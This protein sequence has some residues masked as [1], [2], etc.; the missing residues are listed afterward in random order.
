VVRIDVE[1]IASA[2]AHAFEQP[3]EVVAGDPGLL[4]RYSGER[5]NA[6]FVKKAR[7]WTIRADDE[8]ISFV[9]LEREG[10]RGWNL[11]SDRQWTLFPYTTGHAAIAREIA[12]MIVASA[13]G[14][15][16]NL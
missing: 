14:R 7:N 13:T 6:A 10:G 8:G 4:L 9:E 11:P 12:K 15:S 3:F 5:T 16:E 2:L 1:E